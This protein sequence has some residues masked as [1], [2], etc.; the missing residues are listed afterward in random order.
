M[1]EVDMHGTTTSTLD[2][3]FIFACIIPN[4]NLYLNI[5]HLNAAVIVWNWALRATRFIPQRVGLKTFFKAFQSGCVF[6]GS[7]TKECFVF[8]VLS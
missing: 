5:E 6:C 4:L 2:D 7:M 1:I 8:S 3:P